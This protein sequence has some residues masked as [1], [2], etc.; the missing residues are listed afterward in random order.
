MKIYCATSQPELDQY[1]G[2]DA[3]IKCESYNTIR[4]TRII[5]AVYYDDRFVFYNVNE[6]YESDIANMKHPMGY[7]HSAFDSSHIPVRSERRGHLDVVEPLEV[8]TT[9]ELFDLP[10]YHID[11]EVTKLFEYLAGTDIWV[12]AVQ[13][14]DQ[15]SDKY[16]HIVK[17]DGNAI[18]YDY[19]DASLADNPEDVDIESAP[20]SENESL[21]GTEEVSHIDDWEV[22]DSTDILTTAEI[23][24]LYQLSEDTWWENQYDEYDEED[25]E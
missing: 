20:P 22:L 2:K 7:Y 18:I 11:P 15:Y 14:S 4:W 3:W 6:L 8:K 17:K 19:M 1:I 21:Y 16:I 13:R 23:D 12:R 10:D 5:R 24:T 25:E 9:Q